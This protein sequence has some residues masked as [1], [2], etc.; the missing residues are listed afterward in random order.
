MALAIGD[1]LQFTDVQS[2]LGQRMLNVYT[3][4]VDSFESLVDYDDLAQQFEL[5]IITPMLDL[6][7]TT[8]EHETVL[9]RNL[10]SGVD[11][12][13]EPSGQTGGVAGEAFP[14]F[15][16]IGIR[17]NRSTALTRHGQKRVGGIPEAAVSGNG[18]A[19]A[20]VA[21]ADVLA[22]AMA[23]PIV[24][25][26]TQDED[27]VLTPVIVGRYPIGDPNAGQYDLSKV[28]EVSSAQ[29]VSVTSQTTRKAGRGI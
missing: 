18:L 14:S 4:R 8:V 1:I 5:L 6:Q 7:V 16:A 11:I 23:D 20:F 15:V 24:K 9:V 26:G 3:Y 12:W 10:T 21:A 29:V 22:T 25:T 19:G 2:Y 27:F 17:L 28:N 13:E